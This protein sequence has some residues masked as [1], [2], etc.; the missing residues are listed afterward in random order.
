MPCLECS[1]PITPSKT[2]SPRRFCS[3]ACAKK[4]GNRAMTRGAAFYH[5]IRAHRRERS[6]S[7][8][9]GLW[10]AICQLE[11]Y[12]NDIDAGKRTYLPPEMVLADIDAKDYRPTT[13]LFVRSA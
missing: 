5:L 12:Y 2:G 1:A 13:N 3:D 6:K 4:F 11:L 7:K 8:Q 10:T 9:L